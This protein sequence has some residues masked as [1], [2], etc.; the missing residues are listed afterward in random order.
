MSPA[1][2]ELTGGE[3]QA[4]WPPARPVAGLVEIGPKMP[5]SAKAWNEAWVEALRL[6]RAPAMA[7]E[8][9]RRGKSE[10][11]M[12]AKPMDVKTNETSPIV[13]QTGNIR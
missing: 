10:P 1:K 9:S 3:S 11:N 6:G 8:E 5:R 12:V 4:I 13:L 2:K 7:V